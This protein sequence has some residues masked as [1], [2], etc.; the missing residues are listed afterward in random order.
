MI[1]S[2]SSSA[3]ASGAALGGGGAVED[4]Q[5]HRLPDAPEVLDRLGGDQRVAQLRPGGGVGVAAALG[6][7][8]VVQAPGGRGVAEHRAAGAEKQLVHGPL[9]PGGLVRRGRE[10]PR[11]AP[12][13]EVEGELADP[14]ELGQHAEQDFGAHRVRPCT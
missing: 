5:A 9:G 12:L 8:Q 7:E 14:L 3:H 10:Q 2:A 6:D 13:D 1:A 11:G 4:V